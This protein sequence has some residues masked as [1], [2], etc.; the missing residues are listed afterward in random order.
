MLI[1]TDPGS[2]TGGL[3]TDPVVMDTGEQV[4]SSSDLSWS[5]K[6][7]SLTVKR[8]YRHK[9]ANQAGT[10]DFG[11]YFHTNLRARVDESVN[12]LTTTAQLGDGEDIVFIRATTGDPFVAPAGWERY[13]LQEIGGTQYKL[14]NRDGFTYTFQAS[15]DPAKV[16]STLNRFGCGHEYQYN[17]SGY[18]TAVYET[19]EGA[20]SLTPIRVD[21]DAAN[22]ITRIRDYASRTVEYFYDGNSNLTLA[23]DACGSCSSIPTAEYAY[24]A[25]DRITTI[26]DAAGAAVLTISYN[27][28]TNNITSYIDANGGTY[29]FAYGTPDTVIDPVGN[30]TSYTFDGSGNL[31]TKTF[32][33]E[34]PGS[35]DDITYVYQYDASHRATHATL[36]NG[37]TVRQDYDAKGNLLRRIVTGGGSS[38]T[39]FAAEYE[40]T[41]SQPTKMWD[42]L[43]NTTEYAYSAGGARTREIRPGALTKTF[44]VRASGQVTSLV[45]T[46]GKTGAYSYDDNGF[47]LTKEDDGGGLALQTI[48]VVDALGRRLSTTTAEGHLSTF[49][50]NKAGKQTKN[51]T[52]EGVVTQY[53]YDGN[54]RQTAR[55]VMDG[56]T[57]K[58]IWTTSY[59]T[60]GHPTRMIDPNN[61][62]MTYAY[63]RSGRL[64]KL[65]APGDDVT[66]WVFDKLGRVV[67]AKTGD[68]SSTRIASIAT[69]DLMGNMV[70]QADAEGNVTN[71]AYDGFGRLTKVTGATGAY[72]VME[73]DDADRQTALQRCALGGAIETRTLYAYDGANRQT[74]VRLKATP[75]G[76]DSSDDSLTQTQYDGENRVTQRIV[77]IDASNSLTT[78]S[79]FDGAGR[80]TQ[81][82][83]PDSFN[84]IY[85]YD[86]DS[87]RTKVTDP[88][89]ST[90][91]YAYDKDGRQTKLTNATG[92]Y[93]ETA[94]DLLLGVQT[95]VSQYA[96]GATLLAKTKY[97]YDSLGRQTLSRRKA[98]PGGADDNATDFVEKSFYDT[99]G[100]VTKRTG[101]SGNDTTYVYDTFG[102][103]T[104]TTFPG[105]DYTTSAFD[106]NGTLTQQIRYEIVSGN[107]RS[108]R[109]DHLVDVLS[110]VTKTTNQGPDGTFGNGDDLN[111]Q[112]AYDAV[113]RQITITNEA[114]RFTVSEY[115]AMGRRTRVTED[116]AGIARN[117]DSR[118]DRSGRLERLI[119]F[120]DGT[121]NPQTT[122]YAYN[123]RG[124]QTIV[125]Y[126][127]T[128]N[129]THG[130]DST[131]NMTKRTD[132]A[133][134]VVDYKYDSANRLTER[135]KNGSTDNVEKYVY[136]GLGRLTTAKK[137]TTTTDDSVSRSVFAY[138][139][140]S[141]VTNEAQSIAAATAKNVNYSYDK[142][143]NR[144]TML[145]HG[146]GA[147]ATYAYDTRDRCT[148]VSYNGATL[149]GYTWLG[150][151]LSKRVTTCDYPGST[152]PQF[153]SDFQRDGIGR[154]TSLVNEHLTLDMAGS[155]Y[156]GLGSFTYTYDSAGNVLTAD[157]SNLGVY[158][159]QD[160]INTYDT[161]DRLLTTR[162]ED[163]QQWGP[164]SASYTSWYQ[165]DDLGNRQSHKYR[166]DSA[167]AYA[168][169]KAN[170]MTTIATVTQGYDLAGNLTLAYS[171]DRG[172]SYTY[173]YDHNNRLTGVYDSTNTTR[174]A[175]F[176]WDALGRR[177][178][179]VNDVVSSTARYFFDG[180]NE[181]AEFDGADSRIG[182]YVHGV[183]YV[184][185]HLLM[186]TGSKPYYYV[187]DRMYNVRLLLDR[188]GA[189][190]ER[191]AYDSYGRPRI[192][193]SCGRGDMNDDTKMTSTDTTRFDDANADT[194]WDPRADMDDDGDVDAGDE[195]AYDAKYSDWSGVSPTVDPRQAFSAKGNPYMFQGIPHFALDT[196]SAATEGKLMLNHH[197]ARFADPVTGRWTMR[198][199]LYYNI[200]TIGPIS[201]N[202]WFALSN[203]S[204]STFEQTYE[205]AVAVYELLAT[206]P[207]T[208]S[209]STGL[210]TPCGTVDCGCRTEN[211]SPV[212]VYANSGRAHAINPGGCVTLLIP[213]GIFCDL[214][215]GCDDIAG[216]Q[217]QGVPLLEHECCHVCDYVDEGLCKYL[218]GA[219]NDDCNSRP[220][221]ADASRLADPVQ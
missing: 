6:G 109:T 97:E 130:Y 66:E 171:A 208:R 163:Y 133:A 91:S 28:V 159:A 61:R 129:V 175:T 216:R 51:T 138:D 150:N 29:S 114:G 183:S 44:L 203:N 87:R 164:T 134:V 214:E 172:T 65:T 182:H 45:D 205:A 53:E 131:G 101:A 142:A 179:H 99:D 116:S 104:K 37:S 75:G 43:G 81:V 177:I 106:K 98:S 194:I 71:R 184:D 217:S 79:A 11:Q 93:T 145:H 135:L 54:S 49:L 156:G 23:K 20:T 158:L 82:T 40:S 188:A 125:T 12:E 160:T 24:D 154:V 121:S 88:R 140:L 152:K 94:Y 50:Y 181:I 220:R 84:T 198:D 119:A 176:T 111:V 27:G 221:S 112:Y 168:H 70:T 22:A 95:Q 212:P 187:L 197:R 47:V 202:D 161:A 9:T 147:T 215:G 35:G 103:Q 108:F 2:P 78:T 157:N 143:G 207:H 124:L 32:K 123:G 31:V 77:W 146:G 178:E 189:I 120:T 165:Y 5:F 39:K 151:A 115:D 56:A 206:S 211:P 195:T 26:K 169:D 25:G 68:T 166:T 199:P 69:Y 107:T 173:R 141:R 92:D 196:S 64:T 14:K 110:R 85:A 118:F 36:P 213:Y 57:P 122:Q 117:T 58:Y 19:G 128:G 21:R 80:M 62:T 127:D 96:N 209:D 100:R 48:N 83:D 7:A 4:F 174:K 167:I 204:R 102:L 52:A 55:K 180:V 162:Y 8:L 201:S 67:T 38:V 210:S 33:M 42:G 1:R 73:Y 13:D 3:I 193:E 63:D 139:N 89:G 186:I 18:V 126:E 30:T 41:Y 149:A 60:A 10:A 170:R 90:T 192:R 153:K 148:Q 15:V 113:G 34:E 218:D 46:L 185:E 105:G 16:V 219:I 155:T 76:A 132:E 59:D 86:G 137:G 144:I 136:D 190:V 200:D 191:Y 72:S 74:S 17:A